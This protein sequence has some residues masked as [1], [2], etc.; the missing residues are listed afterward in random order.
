MRKIWQK[1]LLWKALGNLDGKAVSIET[2]IDELKKYARYPP[3]LRT[4]TLWL[5][6]EPFSRC[7]EVRSEN[8]RGLTQNYER[9]VYQIRISKINKANKRNT[10]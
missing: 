6:K 2:I 7:V 1:A 3:S 10:D 8:I 5:G 4:V 9:N